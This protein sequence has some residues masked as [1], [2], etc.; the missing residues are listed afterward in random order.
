M[1]GSEEDEDVAQE[2]GNLS[3]FSILN[4]TGIAALAQAN[5]QQ[6]AVLIHLVRRPVP[7]P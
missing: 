2:V 1:L 4:Q 5:A 6:Q 7:P 3:R